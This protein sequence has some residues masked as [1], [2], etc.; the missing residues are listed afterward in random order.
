MALDALPVEH[1]LTLVAETGDRPPAVLPAPPS[2]TRII[3]TA[4]RGRF[5]GPKLR[6]TIADVAGGDWV[7]R[8]DDGSLKLDVRLVLSTDDGAFI[9]MTYTGIA[10]PAPDGGMTVRVAPQFET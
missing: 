9:F 5:D 10:A 6:G 2:G 8:R 7:I 1:L 4:M 3:V